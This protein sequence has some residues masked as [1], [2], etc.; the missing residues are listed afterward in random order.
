VP[1]ALSRQADL[2][3]GY[4]NFL[5]VGRRFLEATAEAAGALRLG[6]SAPRAGTDRS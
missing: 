6:L 3:H 4:V 5:G 1:V 2:I